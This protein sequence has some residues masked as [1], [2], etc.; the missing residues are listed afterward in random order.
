MPQPIGRPTPVPPAGKLTSSIKNTVRVFLATGAIVTSLLG[1]QA[2]MALDIPTIADTVIINTTVPNTLVTPQNTSVA[3]LP[4]GVEVVT[5]VPTNTPIPSATPSATS[6][7]TNTSVGLIPTKSLASATPTLTPTLTST[8]TVK[9]T[10]TVKPTQVPTIR[11][12]VVQP[13][14]V[15]SSSRKR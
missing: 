7:V 5:L 6:T 3:N 10:A 11:V 1:A 14:P 15:T 2:L 12:A 9:A 8:A 13:T 4:S